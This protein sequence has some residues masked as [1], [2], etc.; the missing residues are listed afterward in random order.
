MGCR[1]P[2][3]SAAWASTCRALVACA[4]S[5]ASACRPTTAAA[6][7]GAGRSLRW[8]LHR[9]GARGSRRARAAW[10]RCRRGGVLGRTATHLS[11]VTARRLIAWCATTAGD[12]CRW[13]RQIRAPRHVVPCAARCGLE[14]GLVDSDE[15]F[16]LLLGLFDSIITY[17]ARF[18][19][20]REMLPL[21]DLLVFDTDSTLLAGVVRTLR[22]RLRKLARHDGAWA[23]EVTDP[24]PT[25]EHLV[26]RADGRARCRTGGL[27]RADRRTA[28]HGRMRSARAVRCNRQPPVRA[29]GG[30]RPLGV[31]V[32]PMAFRR[33]RAHCRAACG[34]RR[35]ACVT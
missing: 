8:Q 16:N 3:A 21:L 7:P 14:A 10:R 24:L 23:C 26:D 20:R 28:S 2:P 29:R 33:R 32:T 34:R 22:D 30:C 5:C 6:D 4:V 13:A 9:V 12:C 15:G 1:L 11:A 35:C 19:G 31:A 17:R 27:H 25:P 18:Q